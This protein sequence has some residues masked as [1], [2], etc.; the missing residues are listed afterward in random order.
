MRN[1]GIPHLP[2]LD[3]D[4][5]YCCREERG[6]RSS[7]GLSIEAIRVVCN[8]LGGNVKPFLSSSLPATLEDANGG[9]NSDN[10]VLHHGIFQG[11]FL[12]FCRRDVVSIDT[13]IRTWGATASRARGQ[14]S[15]GEERT[16]SAVHGEMCSWSHTMVYV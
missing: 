11:F 10:D 3:F 1:G 7:A 14:C 13:F 15:N 12:T 4:V 9:P 5:P 8:K 16:V 2:N 6:W